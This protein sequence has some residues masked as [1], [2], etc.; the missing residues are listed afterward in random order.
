MLPDSPSYNTKAS[1]SIKN[2]VFV[3]QQELEQIVIQAN[4]DLKVEEVRVNMADMKVESKPVELLT[5]VGSCVAI[6]IYD[7]VHRC[8]GLAHIMLPDSTI[9]TREPLPPKYADTAVPA[10]AK[11][12]RYL[13]G[14]DSRLTAKIAGGA[15]MFV[16]LSNILDIGNKNVIAVKKA[17]LHHR[18]RLTGEDV[19]GSHGRRVSFNVASGITIVRSHD[20]ESKKL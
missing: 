18:I 1:V 6:C 19:G 5:S 14:R 7:S 15:N 20:G 8:G 10:L 17:L 16:H 12:I 13:T 3:R 2:R 4:D 11:E 9:G